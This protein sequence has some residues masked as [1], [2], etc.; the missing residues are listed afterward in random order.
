MRDF[1][2]RT[3]G[4]VEVCVHFPPIGNIKEQSAREI[5]HGAKAQEIRQQTI[6][7]DRLCLITCLS[8]KTLMDKVSMGMKLLKGQKHQAK[9]ML[10][11]T[12][13]L[14]EA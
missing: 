2:I 14:G 4:K 3:D 10:A 13:G 12:D 5:W 1:F 6:S 7:C 9:P 11:T 8:Q